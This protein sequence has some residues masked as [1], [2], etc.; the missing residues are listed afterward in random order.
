[1][2]PVV[3]V[4]SDY[5]TGK[6]FSVFTYYCRR[7]YISALADSGA[8]PIILPTT[9][10]MEAIK[11]MG[12]M[13]DGLLVTGGGHDIDPSLYGEDKVAPLGEIKGERSQFELAI[14]RIMMELG[15][16]VLGICNGIQ[17]INVACG[18]SLIQ[19]IPSQVPAS[20]PHRQ[21]ETR[22]ETSHEVEILE[23][24]KLASIL[25]AGRM[26]V[27]SLHHQAVKDLGEG[28]IINAKAPDGII[29]GVEAPQRPF[30]IGVQWHPED[31]YKTDPK[32]KAL[33][34]S[35]VRGCLGRTL[36][37]GFSPPPASIGPETPDG[38]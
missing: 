25:G 27:N 9:L 38:S 20:L 16:P 33:F 36:F 24:T 37:K 30:I 19:D 31:L 35:F 3:G 17:V 22:Q 6:R 4:T 29:E 12:E 34:S 26:M 23:G 21:K 7:T 13:L 14:T 8:L 1:M 15:R 28:L 18:G 10:D 2:R 5:D 11:G 32:M